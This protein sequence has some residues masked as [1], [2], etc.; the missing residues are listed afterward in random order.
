MTQARRHWA[1][2]QMI[3]GESVLNFTNRFCEKLKVIEALGVKVNKLELLGNYAIALKPFYEGVSRRFDSG[4]EMTFEDMKL[5]TLNLE[6]SAKESKARIEE[7]I[8]T[9][10]ANTVVHVVETRL[11]KRQNGKE[12][13]INIM[14]NDGEKKKIM[15]FRCVKPNHTTTECTNPKEVCYNCGKLGSHTAKDC[16][17]PRSSFPQGA[18]FLPGRITKTSRS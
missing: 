7:A 12:D 15:R 8:G 10:N 3:E 13:S 18:K 2:L 17:V 6:S 14:K 9:T 1:G 5:F 11:Q 4:A 16:T